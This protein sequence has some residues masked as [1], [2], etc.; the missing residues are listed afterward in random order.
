LERRVLK[1]RK[2]TILPLEVDYSDNEKGKG[3]KS[4]DAAFLK[5]IDKLFAINPKLTPFLNTLR[6]KEGSNN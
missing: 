2:E 4:D 1:S 6:G 3:R 5:E